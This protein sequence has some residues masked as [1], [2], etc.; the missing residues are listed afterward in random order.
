MAKV[1]AGRISRFG[2]FVL[3]KR[4]KKQLATRRNLFL[5][6]LTIGRECATNNIFNRFMVLSPTVFQINV[7]ATCNA[8]CK[9]C[10]I[11]HKEDKTMLSIN[12]LERIFSDPIFSRIEYVIVSGGEPTL[13]DDLAE[14]VLLMIQKMPGL[15][16]ISIPTN[17]IATNK[18]VSHFRKIAIACI[19]HD[20]LLSVGVSLD[21]VDEVYERARGVEGGYQKV[22]NTISKLKELNNELEFNFSIGATLSGINIYDAYNLVQVANSLDIDINFV[23]AAMSE[24]YFDNKN[25]AENII[26]NEEQRR[27]FARFLQERMKNSP[28]ISEMPFYYEKSLEM[29]NGAKRSMPCPYQDQGLVL[30]ADGTLHYCTN[31]QAIGNVH[32]RLSSDIYKDPKNLAYRKHLVAEVCPGCQISCFIGVGLRKTLFP[33]LWFLADRVFRKRMTV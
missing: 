31:S 18:C 30:N 27:F 19:E 15:R 10:N 33:F 23:V 8:R 2:G 28:L 25:L 3:T 16:K 12:E 14:V 20:V 24:S 4:L 7:N 5:E 9:V 1:D 6:I 32:E 29:L 26:L 11:W 22:I 17:G 21:G 13:R